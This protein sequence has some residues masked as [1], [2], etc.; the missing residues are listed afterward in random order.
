MIQVIIQFVLENKSS[1][2]LLTTWGGRAYY[3]LKTG[4]GLKGIYRSIM[5]G[6]NT[7]KKKDEK[8]N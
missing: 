6:T 4:G 1:I 8:I 3:S 7:P 5:F 2:A